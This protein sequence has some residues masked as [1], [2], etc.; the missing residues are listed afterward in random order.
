MTGIDRVDYDDDPRAPRAT[1]IV[2]AASAI[3]TDGD[4][5][6]LL[7]RRTDN[8]LWSIPGGQMEVGETISQT[9]VRE[10][11]EETGLEVAPDRLVGIYTDPRHV[12]AYS[13]GEARQEFSICFACR[14]VGGELLDRGDESL[15]VG[16]FA[17]ERIAEMSMH[18]SI[19]R[20]I[21][22]FLDARDQPAID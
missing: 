11:R 17:P 1:R 21:A 7:H 10:V 16:F 5:R 18:R 9:V 2:P 13:D 20:R 6:I 4:G 3:V 19:R 8:A 22:D 15:A 12:I 14:P